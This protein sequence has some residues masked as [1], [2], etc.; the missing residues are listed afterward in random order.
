MHLYKPAEPALA[1]I[2]KS[3][4]CTNGKKAAGFVRH[5]EF[6]VSGSDL[7]GKCIPGQSIGVIPQGLD[8]QGKPHKLRLYSLASP[9]AGEDGQGRVLSTTVKR[10]IDEHWDSHQLFLGV[11]SNYLCN[12]KPGDQIRVSGPNGKRFVLPQDVNAHDYLFFATGTGIAP[13]RG[14]LLDLLA[15]G[16]TRQIVLVMGSPYTTDLLYHDFF[17]RIAS[18]HPN[19]TYLTAVSRERNDQHDRLYVQDRLRTDV[20]RLTPVLTGGKA[21]LYIC[22]LAGMEL[23]IFQE[24][25]LRL[26]PSALEHFLQVDREALSDIRRWSRSMIHKEVRP[27]RNVFMEVYA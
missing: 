9:T 13:F 2:T 19:F 18:E 27:T 22:G 1:V 14:M 24:L 4:L 16:C 23:G 3:E 6:D 17:V 15:A 26:N 8:A 5:I 10:T 20:D 25:A 12:L 7:V 11:C 21:L